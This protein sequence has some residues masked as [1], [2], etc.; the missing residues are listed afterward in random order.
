MIRFSP[1]G[2]SAREVAESRRLHGD[3]V[4]APPR[5]EPAWRLLAEKFRD[6]IIKV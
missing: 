2:L 1:V 4:I 5:D 6:P 3:N